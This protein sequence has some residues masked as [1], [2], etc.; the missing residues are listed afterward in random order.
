M[1][2]S[3]KA[4][5]LA[6]QIAFW[7]VLATLL[8][9]VLLTFVNVANV[10]QLSAYD[11]DWNDLS[12]FREDLETMGVETRSLVSSPCCLPTST[13]PATPRTSWPALSETPSHCLNLTRMD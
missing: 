8:L 6:L 11:D 9:S 10:N 4:R 5:R 2:A 7:T 12:S 13:T 1:E 3:A